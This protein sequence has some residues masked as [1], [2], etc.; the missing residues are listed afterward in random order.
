MFFSWAIFWVVLQL[1]TAKQGKS[2]LLPRGSGE[3]FYLACGEAW[4]QGMR[5]EILEG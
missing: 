4:Q 1:I 3:R 2:L 5:K